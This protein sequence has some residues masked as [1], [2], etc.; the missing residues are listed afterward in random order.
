MFTIGEISKLFQIDVRTLR[1]YDDI[2]LF[3]PASVDH[4]NRYRYYSVHQFEQLNTILYLKTLGIPLKEIKLFLDDREIDHILTLLKE[5]QRR[6]KEKI[7]E[8]QRIQQKI[9]SRIQQIEDATNKEELYKIREVQIPERVIVLLKQKIH[10]GDNLELPIRLLENSTQMHSTIFLGKIGLLISVDNLMKRK[11][12]EYNSIFVIVEQDGDGSSSGAEVKI[13]PKDKYISIR[14]VGTHEDAVPYY[15]KLLDYI[16]QKGF[17]LIEDAVEITYI[18]YGLTDDPSQF[19]TEIQ[20][21][22]K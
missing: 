1:Y 2:D 10:K 8:F 16:E 20:M 15:G 5:Q 17:Q 11:F 19:V 18:D 12:D 21:L 9:T 13:L 4:L 14:F 22:A 7:Q 3:K 6:T